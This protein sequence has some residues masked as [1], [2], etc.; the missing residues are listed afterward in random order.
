M[1]RSLSPRER[2]LRVLRGERP[3]CVPV[4]PLSDAAAAAWLGVPYAKLT[5]Q[6]QIRHAAEFEI[7]LLLNTSA[8]C[9]AAVDDAW[10]REDLGRE[11]G[12]AVYRLTLETPAG[13]LTQVVQDVPYA[14][15]W[16]REFPIKSTDD[17]PAFEYV[18]DWIAAEPDAPAVIA[19]IASGIGEAGL[20]HPWMIVP[21]ELFGWIEREEAMVFALESPDRMRRL[22]EKIHTGQ[23]R[24]AASALAKGA[25]ILAFGIPGTELTSPPL[26]R[27]FA[28]PYARDLAELAAQ[29]QRWSLL[30][31]CGK[32]GQLLDEIAAIN[33]SLFETCAPPPEGDTLDIG[34]VRDRIGRDITAKGN[35]NLTFLAT[36][37][38][39]EVYRKGR[40]IIQQ[41][42]TDR[43]MLSVS[44][45]LL[46]NH[47]PENVRA[48][49]RAGHEFT[50]A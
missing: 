31:M 6:D 44:D 8:A 40:E 41:A 42:G 43:F 35:M 4:A 15:G 23:M 28:L 18:M 38:P 25:D 50:T 7:D 46:A 11:D 5:W 47:P 39:A 3:D 22:C 32:I 26:F 27:E 24:M 20:I 37:T 17:L 36:A 1:T 33:P 16:T 13:T 49:V 19:E 34:A 2:L 9:P 30:H 21:L 10:R 29:R 12:C 14:L 45:V 48:L